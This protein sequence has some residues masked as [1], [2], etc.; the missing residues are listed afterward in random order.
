MKLHESLYR[1]IAF[2]DLFEHPLTDKEIQRFLYGY[3]K[4][5]HIK[6]IQG[7]LESLP[8]II[9]IKDYFMLEGR[10]HLVSVRS[11]RRFISEKY[12]QRVRF[13][14]RMMMKIPFIRMIG[15]C[16]NLA[17]DNASHESD[18]DLFVVVEPGRLW[19]ARLLLTGL[20]HFFG[21]RR[22]GSK[23]AGRFCLSF[24]ADTNALDL[25]S[26]QIAPHDPY[27][28]YWTVLLSPFF[29]QKTYRSF[30]KSNESWLKP[31]G[32]RFSEFSERHFF[33]SDRSR[34]RDFLE[35][36]LG[37][38]FGISVEKSIRK[39]LLPRALKKAQR[40]PQNAHLI[41]QDDMLK[42]HNHDRRKEYLNRWE[43]QT[44]KLMRLWREHVTQEALPSASS[45]ACAGA[46]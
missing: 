41:I 18:I 43:A 30:Q 33:P 22:H 26:L 28:A 29:G 8:G 31:Y 5:V 10:E 39:R 14:G 11:Q 38:R 1:T 42:F 37:G 34:L 16:N 46:A 3:Q 21:V 24:F 9:R 25:S 12:W 32:L 23:V 45:D 44:A 27:L 35:R 2:F 17:Y 40:A 4:P 19:T 15:V 7:T 13:Y 6:E 36:L 20:L